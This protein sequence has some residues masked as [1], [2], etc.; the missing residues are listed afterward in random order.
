MREREI[1]GER[2]RDVGPHWPLTRILLILTTSPISVS[3]HF[4]FLILVCEI[5]LFNSH[6]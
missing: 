4:L 6:D 5:S 3:L 1:G 2:E